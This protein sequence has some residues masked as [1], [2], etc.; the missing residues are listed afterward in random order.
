MCDCTITTR[1]IPRKDGSYRTVYRQTFICK[2]HRGH[3]TQSTAG[4]LAKV[5]ELLA[6]HERNTDG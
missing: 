6:E 2:E 3:D 5:R 4:R 1:Y